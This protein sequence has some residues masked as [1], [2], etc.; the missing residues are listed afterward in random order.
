[1]SESVGI[2]RRAV[3]SDIKSL[4][5]LLALYPGQL[6]P[7]SEEAFEELI[8]TTWVAEEGGQV[9]GCTTLE[10]YSPKICE[11]RSVAVRAGFRHQGYGQKLVNLAVEEARSRNIKQILVV[12]STPEFFEKLNFGPCLNEKY[13]LFWNGS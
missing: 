3:L 6:L 7:R 4:V 2:V 9:V 8:D 5:E 13:A 11:I 10:V 1:M 12:T